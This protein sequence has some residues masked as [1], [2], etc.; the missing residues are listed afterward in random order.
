MAPV[1]VARRWTTLANIRPEQLQLWPVVKLNQLSRTGSFTAKREILFLFL[2][3]NLRHLSA[4][5]VLENGAAIITLSHSHTLYAVLLWYPIKPP[6]AQAQMNP[7]SSSY[8]L[9]T[10]LP[11]WLDKSEGQVEK[12]IIVMMT[13]KHLSHFESMASCSLAQFNSPVSCHFY[14]IQHNHWRLRHWD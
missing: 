6:R 12:H 9:T 10:R 8:I 5:L 7:G 14:H 13:Y 3:T 4:V 1:N 11:F 2:V